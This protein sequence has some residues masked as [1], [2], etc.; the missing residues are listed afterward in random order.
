MFTLCR[1]SSWQLPHPEAKG[2]RHKRRSRAHTRAARYGTPP[3]QLAAMIEP[4]AFFSDWLV[5]TR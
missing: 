5:G 1:V 2:R 4:C 3:R